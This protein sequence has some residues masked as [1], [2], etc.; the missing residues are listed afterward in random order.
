MLAVLG[1]GSVLLRSVLDTDSSDGGASATPAST[2]VDGLTVSLMQPVDCGDDPEPADGEAAACNPDGILVGADTYV[3]NA[4]VEVIT[5]NVTDGLFAACAPGDPSSG[6]AVEFAYIVEN[7]DPAVLLAG[8]TGSGFVAITGPSIESTT[9]EP[10][11]EV[12][13]TVCVSLSDADAY[14]Q[15]RVLAEP[16]ADEPGG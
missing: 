6:C 16:R 5:A 15:C 9:A 13:F 2:I 3:V 12:L 8:D 10:T 1:L 7:V 14:A 4:D 11:I